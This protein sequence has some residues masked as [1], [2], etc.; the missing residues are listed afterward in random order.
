MITVF[1]R[2]ELILTMSLEQQ[3]EIRYILEANKIDYKLIMSSPISY[4]G[5]TRYICESYIYVNKKDYEKANDLLSS[6]K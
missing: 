2:K 3:S 1:N 6:I 4:S 5:S